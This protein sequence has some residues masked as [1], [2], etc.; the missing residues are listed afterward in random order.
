MELSKE[1]RVF[2]TRVVWKAQTSPKWTKGN[3]ID[4]GTALFSKKTLK[5]MD[6]KVFD[7]IFPFLN[8]IVNSL[9]A[10]L[11]EQAQ[12]QAQIQAKPETE[13]PAQEPEAKES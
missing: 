1:E 11:A 3:L 6:D 7:K 2:F 12:T 4:F 13:T 8:E 10:S 9:G 5:E